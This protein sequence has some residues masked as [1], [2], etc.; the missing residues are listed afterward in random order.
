MLQKWPL[1]EVSRGFKRCAILCGRR[2][3]LWHRDKAVLCD[4]RSTCARFSEDD[5]HFSWQV[6]HFGDL[7]RHFA[8]QGQHFRRVVLRVF[9]ES[10]CQGC[11]KWTPHKTRL[12]ALHTLHSTLYI[13]RLHFTLYTLYTLYTWKCRHSPLYTLHSNLSLLHSTLYTLH[14]ALYTWHSTLHTWHSTL[15]TPRSTLWAAATGCNIYDVFT[16]LCVLTSVP[17]TFAGF[18]GCILFFLF[19]KYQA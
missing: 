3:I 9:C 6:Q 12:F 2:A 11:F 10:Y 4:R 15:Y 17:L 8:R 5:L 13:C 19:F 18:V 7:H 1:L 14:F 16:S